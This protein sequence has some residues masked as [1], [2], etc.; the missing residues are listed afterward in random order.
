M[1]RFLQ[2]HL[3]TSY[4]PANLNRDDLGRPKTAIVGGKQRL[5]V[6]SQSLKRAWR[7]APMFKA[8]LA[9]HIGTRTQ[10]IGVD[11]FA[12]LKGKTTAKNAEA[13]TREVVEV[14]GKAQTGDKIGKTEQLVHIS[15]TER[16][17]LDALVARL[18]D[19]VRGPTPEEKDLLRAEHTAVDIALFG[20]M[21]AASPKHGVDAAAQVAHAI[22]VHP[23]QVEDDYFTAVDDLNERGDTG[24]GHVG[25]AEFGAGVFYLYLCIDRQALLANLGGDAALAGRALGALVEAAATIAPGGKQNSFASRARA[26]YI[27]AE[28]GDQQPRSLSVAYLDGLRPSGALL[29]EAITALRTTRDRFAQCYEA[30]ADREAELNAHAGTGRLADV[31]AFAA[32][33]LGA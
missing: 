7:Q 10:Q 15:P 11:L 8:A 27:L 31:V 32:S 2:L 17:A 3:L 21:L 28:L 12:G 13:W 20:R 16:A 19:E 4:P 1:S 33:G 14:F 30:G 26:S 9:G 18:I 5:R 25:Q 24:A 29:E 6:S 22:T 23:A